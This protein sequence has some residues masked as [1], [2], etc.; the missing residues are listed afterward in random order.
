MKQ[1]I[2]ATGL[3]RRYGELNVVDHVDI[4]LEPGKVTALLGA[5]GAGK[6]TL[7]RMLAGLEKPDEGSIKLGDT[8]LSAPGIMV[9]AEQRRIG[10]IFQDFALFPHMK[11]IDNVRFGLTDLSRTEGEAIAADWLVR[12]GLPDRLQAYPHQL[13]GG[14][15]QRVAIARALAPSPVAILMDEPFSGL[16]PALRDEVRTAA[17]SAIQNVEIPAL[18]VSHDAEEAMMIA[19]EIAIMD[20]GRIIQTGSPEDLYSA[21]KSPVAAAAL[22]PVNDITG[23]RAD[24]GLVEAVIGRLKAP[25]RA[26]NERFRVMFRPDAVRFVESG[27]T[28]A[29][30]A[31]IRRIGHHYRA[32]L[33]AGKELILALAS[34]SPG[35]DVGATANIHIDPDQCFVFPVD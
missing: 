4:T 35:I 5:S 6:S 9:P 8:V 16:D 32:E 25:E 11:A 22:G 3:A 34:D 21:P 20:R 7:L 15:Q 31:S 24:D 26:D 18:V 13:S 10:L 30:L 1:P 17:L 14:E 28:A 23:T 19:D 12:L 2:I 33:E 27:G 29:R